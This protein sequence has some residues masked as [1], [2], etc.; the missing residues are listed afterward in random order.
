[1]GRWCGGF[2]ERFGKSGVFVDVWGWL[3]FVGG[4]VGNWGVGIGI[5]FLVDF[6]SFES[7]F[8]AAVSVFCF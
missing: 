3:G 2:W 7:V 4:F 8:S 5:G 1:M 6:V